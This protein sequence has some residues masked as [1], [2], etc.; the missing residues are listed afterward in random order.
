MA[1]PRHSSALR[2]VAARSRRSRISSP[3]GR[4]VTGSTSRCL[5][6]CCW[7]TVSRRSRRRRCH[8]AA[9]SRPTKPS[10]MQDGERRNPVHGRGRGS[11]RI[12]VQ[13]SDDAAVA[14]EQR[15]HLAIAARQIIVESQPLEPGSLLQDPQDPRVLAGEVGSDRLQRLDRPPQSLAMPGLGTIIGLP[16]DDKTKAQAGDRRGNENERKRYDDTQDGGF[17]AARGPR[18]MGSGIG[19]QLCRGQPSIRPSDHRRRR[20][21]TGRGRVLNIG[22]HKLRPHATETKQCPPWLKRDGE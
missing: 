10:A 12:P 11:C 14:I 21:I 19:A 1:N 15:L 13:P 6:I 5:R 9:A 18:V 22:Q 4:P 3:L 20:G 8:R 7:L 17:A 16:R 2:P